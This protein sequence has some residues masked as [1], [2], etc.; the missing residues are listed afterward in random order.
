MSAKQGK[1]TAGWGSYYRPI[2]DFHSFS[3]YS[4]DKNL[5]SYAMDIFFF[6]YVF[7]KFSVT[8]NAPCTLEVLGE[9]SLCIRKRM[10]STLDKQVFF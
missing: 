9:V 5:E 8:S 7:I 6:V 4:Q 1:K 2:K 10:Q 3:H